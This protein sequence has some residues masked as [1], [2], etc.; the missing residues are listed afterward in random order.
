VR[1]SCGVALEDALLVHHS[2]FLNGGDVDE[3]ILVNT[4]PE[5]VT[6][7]DL[8]SRPSPV[9]VL[10]PGH[11]TGLPVVLGGCPPEIATLV[12]DPPGSLDPVLREENGALL[13]PEV[14]GLE[15]RGI[16]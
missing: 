9:P 14:I 8:P 3:T 15:R 5:R 7:H 12:V 10:S 2:A 4:R 16:R 11:L 13:R 6:A 1:R